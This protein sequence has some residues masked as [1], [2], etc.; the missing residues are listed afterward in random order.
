MNSPV[1]GANGFEV[2][3]CN[4]TIN[5]EIPTRK[6]AILTNLMKK[7]GVAFLTISEGAIAKFKQ[8][9]SLRCN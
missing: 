6:T 3:R 7:D 1:E 9:S 8:S 4:S 5:G 2:G